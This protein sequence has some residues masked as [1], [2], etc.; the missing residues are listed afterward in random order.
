MCRDTANQ[1]YIYEAGNI[2]FIVT[3]VYRNAGGETLRDVL[4]KLM[5]SDIGRV[6]SNQ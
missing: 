4:I 5:Y 6:M 1:N 2:T 3:P